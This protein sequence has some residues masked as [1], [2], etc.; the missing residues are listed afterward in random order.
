MWENFKSMPLILKFLTAHAIACAGFLVGSVIPHNSFLINGRSVTYVEW[1]SSG[2]G[3]YA[4]V[5]GM[6]MAIA[7][8][9]LVTKNPFS[10]QI[11]LGV[12]SL[13]LVTPY[14]L[15]GEHWSSL[16]SLVIVIMI[17]AYLLLKGSVKEYFAPNKRMQS[18]AS[19]AGAADA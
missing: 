1:W 13:G 17:A 16:F 11:Y 7:G 4:S 19:K 15:F 2:T 9:L 12:L 10:R 14:F 8:F 6:L 3:V 18:D 5:L